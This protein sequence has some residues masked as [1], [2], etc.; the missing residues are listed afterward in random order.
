MSREAGGRG[1]SCRGPEKALCRQR[2]LLVQGAWCVPGAA[3]KDADT[4]M[5]R[6]EWDVMGGLADHAVNIGC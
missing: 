2:D 6:K 5:V 1:P 4:K 3:R